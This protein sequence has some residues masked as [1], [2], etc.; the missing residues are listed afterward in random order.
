MITSNQLPNQLPILPFGFKACKLY[1]LD[2]D[3]Y[4]NAF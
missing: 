1:S 4:G 3:S 2:S